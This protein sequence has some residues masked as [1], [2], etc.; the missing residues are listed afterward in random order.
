[1]LLLCKCKG[2]GKFRFNYKNSLVTVPSYIFPAL[3]D[4]PKKGG[5]N[6]HYHTHFKSALLLFIT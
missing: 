6:T 2:A 3:V 5:Y 4:F 1:M